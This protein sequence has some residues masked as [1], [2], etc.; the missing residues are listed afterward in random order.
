MQ[1]RHGGLVCVRGKK[2]EKEG[3]RITDC[4]VVCREKEKNE[5]NCVFFWPNRL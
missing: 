1:S 4:V 2:R 3:E 5:R